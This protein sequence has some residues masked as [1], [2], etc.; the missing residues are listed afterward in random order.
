MVL[1]SIYSQIID[2]E[3]IVISNLASDTPVTEAQR[4]L[5]YSIPIVFTIHKY[6]SFTT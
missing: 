5:L 6:L 1:S 3:T 4:D 2:I